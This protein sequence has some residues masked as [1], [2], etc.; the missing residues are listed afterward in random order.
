MKATL[1]FDLTDLNESMVFR[2][3]VKAN[4]MWS[5]LADLYRQAKDCGDTEWQQV[6]E[7]SISSWGLDINEIELL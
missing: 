2:K 6:I 4:E 7:S 1:E 3:A 5:C